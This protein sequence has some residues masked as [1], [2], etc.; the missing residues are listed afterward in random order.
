MFYLLKLANLTFIIILM[1]EKTIKIFFN[2][3]PILAM[4]FLIPFVQNDYVLTLLYIII[5]AVALIVKYEKREYVFY[6][7]GFFAMIASEYLFIKTGVEVFERN[8]L[9]GLMPLWLPFLWGY[10]FVAM[11]RAVKVLE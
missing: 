3:I 5:S 1:K 9:F 7:F 6:L 10:G 4:I 11:K 2:L 8:S